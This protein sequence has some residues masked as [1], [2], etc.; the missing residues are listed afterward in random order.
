MAR[1]GLILIL[2]LV[3]IVGALFAFRIIDV[4]QTREAELPE[5]KTEG[6]QLPTF[7]VDTPDI[8]VGTRNETVKV[9]DISIDRPE[10]RT[11][12]TSDR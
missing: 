7:D 1:T 4:Q 8:D 12:N 2:L 5:V 6:G 10:D 9:P 11:E 3:V